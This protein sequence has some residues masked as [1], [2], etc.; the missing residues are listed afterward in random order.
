MVDIHSHVLPGVDDGARSW[1]IAVE[2]CRMAAADGIT[3]MVATPHANDEFAYDR[4]AHEAVLAQ[5]RERVNG[6]IELTLGCD[7]HMSFDNVMTL[8]KNPAKFCI[9]RTNYFLVEFSDFGMSR[10]MVSM[11]KEF[12]D[13]GLRPIITHPERNRTL[14]QT[15][16]T[17]IEMA[18][19][20]CA[21]QV[22]ANSFTGF[23]G[24]VPKKTAQWLL[25]QGAVHVLATDS[26]DPVH[27]RPILSEGRAAVEQLAGEEAAELL[28]SRNP[29]AIVRGESLI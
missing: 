2:M 25:R 18:E 22:T 21:I 3:H 15:P 12:L 26:H 4:Q 17:I 1:E 24:S 13:N 7:V 16:G 20:G 14:Q 23:W 27:R 28:V 6:A 9:G 11:L 8:R 29:E 5:L 19:I 10:M